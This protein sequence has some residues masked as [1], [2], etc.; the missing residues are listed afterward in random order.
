MPQ[1]GVAGAAVG[2]GIAFAVGAAVLVLLWWRGGLVLRVGPPGTW[3][4]SR[5]RR[6]FD[7]GY[8][9]GLEQ[10]VWQGGFLVFLW[11]VSLYGTAPYAA[12]GIGVTLLSFSFLVGWGFSIAASTLVG[13]HLGAGNPDAAARSGWRALRGAMLAQIAFGLAIVA[14]AEPLAR[15]MI[16]DPEVVRLTVVFIYIL[17]SVQPLMAIE[18]AMGGGLRGA[19]DTRYPLFAVFAGLIGARVMLASFFAWYGLPVEWIFAA[20]I[21]DYIVKA[22]LMTL[23]FRSG[24]WKTVLGTKPVPTPT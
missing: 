4:R 20:L 11:I 3:E 5:V 12:Y 10:V 1:L 14:T 8:P 21:A 7:I 13:Q 2:G 16:D 18:Y 9:A 22:T 23:R 24:R 19:G 15:F 6:I 17:G